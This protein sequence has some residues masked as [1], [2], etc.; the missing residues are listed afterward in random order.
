MKFL[1][2]TTLPSEKLLFYLKIFYGY[3]KTI[4]KQCNNVLSYNFSNLFIFIFARFFIYIKHIT[5]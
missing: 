1:A 4:F 5:R 2:K 3:I